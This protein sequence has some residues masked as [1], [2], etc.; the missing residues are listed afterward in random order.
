MVKFHFT[1]SKLG[2]KQFSAKMLTGKF[3]FY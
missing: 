3:Q 1:P 2:E